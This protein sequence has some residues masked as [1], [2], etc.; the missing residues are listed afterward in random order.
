MLGDLLEYEGRTCKVRCTCQWKKG[1]LWGAKQ[2]RVKVEW[3]WWL[4]CI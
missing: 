3:W 2:W 1:P 4:L